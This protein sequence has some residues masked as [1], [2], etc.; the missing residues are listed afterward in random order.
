MTVAICFTIAS[1][2]SYTLADWTRLD[3]RDDAR[4]QQRH[5]PTDQMVPVAGDAPHGAIGA[6]FGQARRQDYRLYRDLGERAAENLVDAG[7][8]NDLVAPVQYV[9]RHA[10]HST[11]I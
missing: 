8:K 4:G 1:I 3:L 2:V 7:G 6:P 10:A 9:A 5:R 11:S